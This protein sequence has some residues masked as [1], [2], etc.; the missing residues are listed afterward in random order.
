MDHLDNAMGGRLKTCTYKNKVAKMIFVYRKFLE[1]KGDVYIDI[2][3][4][5]L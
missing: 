1:A 4:R 5:R 3:Y 2:C